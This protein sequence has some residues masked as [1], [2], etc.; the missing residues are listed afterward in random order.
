MAQ[1]ESVT[2]RLR[3]ASVASLAGFPERRVLLVSDNRDALES[4][5]VLFAAFGSWM[6]RAYDAES[7]VDLAT[8]FPPEIVFIDMEL[9]RASA[10]EVARRLRALPRMHEA[11]IIAYADPRRPEDQN[12]TQDAGFDYVITRPVALSTLLNLLRTS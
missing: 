1:R 3:Q 5:A 8:S 10:F 7:A 9:R 12:A 6:Q 2:R 4:D 11:R